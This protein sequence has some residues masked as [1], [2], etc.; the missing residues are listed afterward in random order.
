[1]ISSIL[2]CSKKLLNVPLNLTLIS[3]WRFQTLGRT[4]APPFST[5][6][7]FNIAMEAELYF[8]HSLVVFWWG[9]SDKAEIYETLTCSTPDKSLIIFYLLWF[10]GSVFQYLSS[11]AQLISC[12]ICGGAVCEKDFCLCD[13]LSVGILYCTVHFIVTIYCYNVKV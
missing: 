2:M 9:H 6:L 3:I 4:C 7:Y 13:A 12:S 11:S 8:T 1:M 5:N 10:V